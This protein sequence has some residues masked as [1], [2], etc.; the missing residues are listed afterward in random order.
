M[1]LRSDSA[2]FAISEISLLSVSPNIDV[3][4][5]IARLIFQSFSKMAILH[6][7]RSQP[8]ISF[9]STLYAI[10]ALQAPSIIYFQNSFHNF[11]F[12]FDL[13]SISHRTEKQFSVSSFFVL[14]SVSLKSHLTSFM[15]RYFIILV[16]KCYSMFKNQWGT[17]IAHVIG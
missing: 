17:H 10:F 9:S 4:R 11:S 7:N 14:R 1:S 13:T 5:N 12:I 8:Q 6:G 2:I 15:N 16:F 3:G